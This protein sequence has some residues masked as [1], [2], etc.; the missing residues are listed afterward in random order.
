MPVNAAWVTAVVALMSI[1]AALIGWSVRGAWRTFRRADRF[2]ED[3][4]GVPADEGHSPRPGVMERLVR[5][6]RQM[7]DVQEQVHLNSGHSLKDAVTRT[8]HAVRRLEAS[9][10]QLRGS[11]DAPS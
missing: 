4:N 7:T 1:L 5:L 11:G 2:L 10:D 3:W 8:E 6:E 9:V